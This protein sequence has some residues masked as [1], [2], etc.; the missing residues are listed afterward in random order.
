MNAA[1]FVFED[2]VG[3]LNRNTSF[4]GGGGG[5]GSNYPYIREALHFW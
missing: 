1:G 4:L 3:T 5:G 2:C